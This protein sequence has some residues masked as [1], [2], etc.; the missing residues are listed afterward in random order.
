[1]REILMRSVMTGSGEQTFKGL[2]NE[3]G[4]KVV[5]Q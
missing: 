2:Y 3:N 4:K 5:I 1:M